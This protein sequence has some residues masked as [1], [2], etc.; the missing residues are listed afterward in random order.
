[1]STPPAIHATVLKYR[2][3]IDPVNSDYLK[4]V[5]KAEC[6]W[7]APLPKVC[8][9]DATTGL[10]QSL[11]PECALRTAQ[12]WAKPDG[13]TAKAASLAIPPSWNGSVHGLTQYFEQMSMRSSVHPMDMGSYLDEASAAPAK[14]QLN[15]E[16]VSME[17]YSRPYP[18]SS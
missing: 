15:H 18:C 1:M 7:V 12:Y 3:H 2:L 4:Q 16:E 14:I 5:D 8:H 13:T 6:G 9:Y 10:H 17:Y 11:G